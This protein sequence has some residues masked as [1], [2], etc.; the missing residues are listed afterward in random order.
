[1]RAC[2]C[3]R[4]V[5]LALDLIKKTKKEKKRMNMTKLIILTN[6]TKITSRWQLFRI[7]GIFPLLLFPEQGKIMSFGYHFFL[8]SIAIVIII[9]DIFIQI[10]FIGTHFCTSS[11]QKSFKTWKVFLKV[12]RRSD[13]QRELKFF[14]PSLYKIFFFQ[15]KNILK[16]Q[17]RRLHSTLHYYN[18]YWS[19]HPQQRSKKYILI[20]FVSSR[21]REKL[22]CCYVFLNIFKRFAFQ[23]Q[24]WCE[25]IRRTKKLFIHSLNVLLFSFFATH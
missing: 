23:C 18:L 24:L 1:M 7:A 12:R 4:L 3:Q 10:H 16:F 2:Y 21:K 8:I 20:S 19:Q 14:L 9:R 15:W 22:F 11:N 13:T 25:K 5:S 17:S 6:I